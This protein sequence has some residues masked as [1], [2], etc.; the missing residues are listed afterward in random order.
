[1]PSQSTL[2]PSIS[3]TNFGQSGDEIALTDDC[4]ARATEDPETG[5]Q[6]YFVSYCN[7][8][9]DSGQMR[10]PFSQWHTPNRDI[11]AIG[12]KLYSLREVTKEAFDLYLDFLKTGME[13]ARRNA[14]RV[15]T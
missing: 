6:R 1:M 10:D 8:G 12:K 15:A 11:P 2:D 5:H 4:F 7:H 3:S 13:A 14:Q 9:N